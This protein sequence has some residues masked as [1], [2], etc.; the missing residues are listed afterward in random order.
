MLLD[1]IWL[2]RPSPYLTRGHDACMVELINIITRLAIAA[3]Y[4]N[5]RLHGADEGIK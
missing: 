2:A 3:Q 4:S 5:G 1:R